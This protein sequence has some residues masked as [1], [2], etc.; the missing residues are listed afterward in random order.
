MS[1]MITG[2]G[3]EV[4]IAGQVPSSVCEQVSGEVPKH[5]ALPIKLKRLAEPGLLALGGFIFRLDRN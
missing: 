1:R 5:R 4:R 3:P 2:F